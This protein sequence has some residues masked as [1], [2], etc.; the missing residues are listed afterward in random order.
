VVSMSIYLASLYNSI[1]LNSAFDAQQI[2][3]IS[4]LNNIHPTAKVSKEVNRNTLLRT[5]RYNNYCQPVH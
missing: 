1:R 2:L 5:R 3:S 4:W